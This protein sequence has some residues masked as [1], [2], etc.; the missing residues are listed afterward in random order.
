MCIKFTKPSI[1]FLVFL[2]WSQ[3]FYWLDGGKW[4]YFSN[5]KRWQSPS[6]LLQRC[7]QYHRLIFMRLMHQF[8]VLGP[9]H[10][11]NISSRSFKK[12][13]VT[14]ENWD[15]LNNFDISRIQNLLTR[16]TRSKNWTLEVQNFLKFIFFFQFFRLMLDKLW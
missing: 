16:S 7:G 5:R 2:L 12:K 8:K 9:E 1:S 4:N 6:I 11:E 10:V 3:Q 15:K 14:R 13:P